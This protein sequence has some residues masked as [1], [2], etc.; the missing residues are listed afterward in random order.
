MGYSQVVKASVFDIDIHW[1]ESNYPKINVTA[2][3]IYIYL[4]LEF[5]PIIKNIKYRLKVQDSCS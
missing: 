2:N 4:K 1:F 5:E 3:K